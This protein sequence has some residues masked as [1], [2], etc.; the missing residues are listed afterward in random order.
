[1]GH[2]FIG[3]VKAIGT[4]VRNIKV[5]DVVVAPFA[6]SDGTCIF[7]QEGCTPHASTEAD[8]AVRSSMEAREKLCA[9]R[10]QM[11]HSLSLPVG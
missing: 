11:A 5:G 4:E 7:C 2:E 1:M 3:V 8:G 9:S 6:W 10:R